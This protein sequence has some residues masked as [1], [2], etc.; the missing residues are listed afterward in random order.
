MLGSGVVKWRN[1]AADS[2]DAIGFITAN[3][4]FYS[5]LTLGILF[6]WN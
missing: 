1:D 3:A 6:F 4:V 2:A 5:V